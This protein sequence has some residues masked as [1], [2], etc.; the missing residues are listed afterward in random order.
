MN[1]NA[2]PVTP[3][4]P[5]R[6]G[7][8]AAEPPSV[9]VHA[10]A[11]CLRAWPSAKA[12]GEWLAAR[13]RR[14]AATL[15]RAG[16]PLA[17]AARALGVRPVDLAAAHAVPFDTD[18]SPLKARALSDPAAVLQAALALPGSWQAA[19]PGLRV[20][21][22]GGRD[23]ARTMAIAAAPATAGSVFALQR[24]AA[25][26]W[27]QGFDAAGDPQWT[28]RPADGQGAG[29]DG[30]VRRFGRL[31]LRGGPDTAS[32]TAST[33]APAHHLATSNLLP[34]GAGWDLLL[35]AV[36]HAL[37]LSLAVGAALRL[38]VAGCLQSV[39]L[40]GRALRVDIGPATLWLN[41]DTPVALAT[42]TLPRVDRAMPPLTIALA[43]G[44]GRAAQCAWARLAA[45]ARHDDAAPACSC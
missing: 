31:A 14:R 27:L 24:G 44:V 5:G 45:A 1:A 9:L 35:Q 20:R 23:T 28:W 3:P 36:A 4:L 42:G 2:M 12:H 7:L 34:P 30:L 8:R 11:R 39:R 6:A 32:G 29:F 25:D 16:L 21:L 26:T 37:P 17:E 10:W 43:P 22:D 18:E 40:D 41:E 19:W 13:L 38:D 15:L 33:G